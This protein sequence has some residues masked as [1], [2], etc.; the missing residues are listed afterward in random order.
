MRVHAGRFSQV[1]FFV[2]PSLV[3]AEQDQSGTSQQKFTGGAVGSVQAFVKPF[4]MFGLGIEV[5][6][7]VNPVRSY[8]GLRVS[9][10]VV[11]YQ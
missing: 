1:A 6:G 10:L 9:I 8:A 4:D 5:Y 11:R 7:N 2:G 3:V